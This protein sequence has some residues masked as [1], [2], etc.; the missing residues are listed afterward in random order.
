MATKSR[1]DETASGISR[2]SV[3]AAL[4]HLGI[5]SLLA[6]CAVPRREATWRLPG[7]G[8]VVHRGDRDFETW[9]R[10]M[11]WQD[12][13]AARTPECIARP[14]DRGQLREA[15][16]HARQQGLRVAIKSGGHNVSE[17]FLREGGMLVDLHH[18]NGVEVDAATASATVEPALWGRDLSLHLSEA[19]LAFPVAH[20]ATVPMGGYLLGGGVGINTDHWGIGCHGVTGAEVMLADGTTVDAGSPGHEDLLWAVRGAGT[21]FF[22][23]VTRYKLRC[24]PLPRDVRENV[25]VFPAARVAEVVQWLEGLVEDGMPDTEVMMLLA[26]SPGPAPG[27]PPVTLCI[28]RVVLFC[29]SESASRERLARVLAGPMA[30]QAVFSETMKAAT[31][32]SLM[33]G[34]VDAARGLG[35][36]RSH[37]NTI[38]TARTAEAATAAAEMVSRAPSPK[39]HAVISLRKHKALPEDAC[40]SALDRGFVGCYGVWDK[41]SDDAV[42]I[43]WSEA[44][45]EALQPFASGNY[46]NELDAFRRP[47]LLKRAFSAEAFAR[48]QAL[49]KRYDPQG[50]FHDFPGLS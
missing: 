34:S 19:G 39:T 1:P 24:A 15:L 9:R 37:V 49:R 45:R 3:L 26:N 8:V 2:R 12:W 40:F 28:A 33:I 47:D 27:A 5:A 44:S 43:A 50:L 31:I 14:A 42:N 30:S 17:A 21:G 36:G 10:A 46:I 41:A 20:C 35:F 22:G 32:D 7:E 4:G 6:G 25:F 23:V 29:D 16:L 13:I 48:L 38:W 18:F 11:P